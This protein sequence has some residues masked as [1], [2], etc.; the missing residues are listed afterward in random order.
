MGYR[1]EVSYLI[2]GKKEAMMPWLMEL[3][4]AHPEV[5]KALNECVLTENDGVYHLGFYEGEIKWYDHIDI[6][7]A[8]IQ[9]WDLAEEAERLQ[10]RRCIIGDEVGDITIDHFGDD[11]IDIYE[12]LGVHR[13]ISV[14]FVTDKSLDIRGK[15]ITI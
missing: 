9:L 10:G 15:E 11:E 13:S 1:S 2:V 7:G 3:K 12:L 8:H 6:V 5:T 14:D 4:M